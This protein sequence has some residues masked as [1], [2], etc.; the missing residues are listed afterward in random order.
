LTTQSE[1]SELSAFEQSPVLKSVIMRLCEFET[2][3]NALDDKVKLLAYFFQKYDLLSGGGGGGGG[4]SGGD[5]GGVGVAGGGGVGVNAEALSTSSSSSSLT[6]APTMT[7]STTAATSSS[8]SATLSSLSAYAASS[9]SSSSS[10]R[11]ASSGSLGNG[12]GD[13]ARTPRHAHM[14]DDALSLEMV[15]HDSK[16][17]FVSNAVLLFVHFANHIFAL[18]LY[19][20]LT[21]ALVLH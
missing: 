6:A 21:D 19:P 10:S 12:G 18:H 8:I 15:I 4:N 1:V 20:V 17:E 7:T 11:P 13:F 9:S 16:G 3:H 5:G 14:T 2:A